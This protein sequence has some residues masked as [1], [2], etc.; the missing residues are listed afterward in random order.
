MANMSPIAPKL[1][2]YQ[3]YTIFHNTSMEHQVMDSEKI[4]SMTLYFYICKFSCPEII[5]SKLPRRPPDGFVTST[6]AMA[7]IFL[8]FLVITICISSQLCFTRLRQI[9]IT[10]TILR[11]TLLRIYLVLREHSQ[12]ITLSDTCQTKCLILR[13]LAR[14]LIRISTLEAS[15]TRLLG[16]TTLP[17]SILT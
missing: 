8:I 11:E 15:C 4:M 13:E 6:F 10:H 16:L 3:T 5:F 2:G 17:S 7:L 14:K 12:K 9:N 1:D